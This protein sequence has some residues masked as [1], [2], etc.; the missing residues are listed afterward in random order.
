MPRTTTVLF[1]ADVVGKPGVFCVKSLLGNLR[2]THQVDLTIANCD[3]ATGGFGLGKRHAAYL[4]KLGVDVITSGECIYYKRDMV[5]YLQEV[6]YVLRPFNYPRQNP[7]HGWATVTARGGARVTVV[8]LL[9]Q[10]GY[11][12]VHA[13]NPFAAADWLAAERR[14]ETP[15]TIVDFHACT[16]AEKR[17][18]CLWMDGKVSAVFGTHVRVQSADEAISAKGTR[19]SHPLRADRQHRLRRRAGP[20]D[21]DPQVAHPDLRTIG[22][23]LGEP[24]VAGGTGSLR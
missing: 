4:H 13:A 23:H 6:R 10:S 9:G 8:C 14:P 22:G 1:V 12:R 7:G 11:D 3:G 19:D 5:P 17:S 20:R 21:R 15:I 16:T 2:R 24:A 18:M